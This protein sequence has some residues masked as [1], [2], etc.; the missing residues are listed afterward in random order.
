VSVPRFGVVV[1]FEAA[2]G[3]IYGH[4]LSNTGNQKARRCD[5]HGMEICTLWEQI[6]A[7]KRVATM[8][9]RFDVK[10]EFDLLASSLTAAIMRLDRFIKLQSRCPLLPHSTCL[11]L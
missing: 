6:R 10:S 11:S 5:V 1:D 9:G 3:K 8:N 4:N 7:R 2:S